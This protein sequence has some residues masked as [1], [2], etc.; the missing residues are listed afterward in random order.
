MEVLAPAGSKESLKA[1]ILGGATAV[2]LG[3]KRYGARNFASNFTDGELAGAVM[4]AH[5]KGVKVYVTVNTLIKERE[6]SDALS[7]IDFLKS[8][9]VDAVIVQ[10]RGLLTLI[11]DDI[12]IPVHAST[13]MGVH[14]PDGAEWARENGIERVILA[15]ELSLEEIGEIKRRS[16]VGLEVFVHGALCYCFSGQCLFSSFAGGRSGNRGMCAQPCRKLYRTV[17]DEG[18]LLSTADLFCIEAIPELIRLGIDGVKIEGRMRSPT[19]VYLTS[20]AYSNAIK[21][22][23]QGVEE[24]ITPRER[25]MLSVAFNRGFS[26]GYL[27]DKV[28]MQRAYADSR[29]LFLGEAKVVS[30]ML[31]LEPSKVGIGDGITLY[32]N[33][34][35]VGGFEVISRNPPG[36]SFRVPFELNDGVYQVYKTKDRGFASIDAEIRAMS[37]RQIEIGRKE[38]HLHLR[39]VDRRPREAD[40]SVYVSSLKTLQKVID[41]VDR[42]YF[43]YAER[44]MEAKEMCRAHDVEFVP[45]LPR[46]TPDIPGIESDRL[47]VCNLD[48]AHRYS[49]RRLYGHYSLNFFNSQTIPNL[50]QSTVS[51]ELSRREI[52]DIAIHYEGRLEVMVFGRVELMVTKD[53]TI[54]T[55]T[56]EDPKGLRFPVYR[57]A[58]GYAHILNCSELLLLEFLDEIEAMGIDSVGIDLRRKNP[59]LAL[60]VAKAFKERDVR[61]KSAIR[62]K[63]GAITTG[64]FLRGVQ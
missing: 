52:G 15:R 17:Q 1:A 16:S 23:E 64:H 56:L 47:M 36:E 41:F 59:D 25:E 28:V 40:I 42:A 31:H 11:K 62:R 43:E 8:I 38:R 35:K 5:S 45:M 63:C 49:D 53:P 24:L 13:Q 18:Y 27:M 55:G 7:N 21:R 12:D 26:K 32:R 14:S 34:E 4:L 57:D 33:A 2:Y 6:L 37:F 20:R 10:D 30:N 9:D 60:L 29:G 3:G 58:F 19:Y 51:V 61:K 44:M 46:V 39:A 22:A 54:N 48:Q 50:Y